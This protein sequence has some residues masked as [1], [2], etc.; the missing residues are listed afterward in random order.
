MTITTITNVRI[1]DGDTV[2]P[3]RTVTLD[4]PTILSVGQPAPAGATIIDGNGGTLLPG[5]IDAHTHTSVESLR[6]ALRFGITTELE[7][8]GHW[9]A[10][11]RATIKATDDLADLR[12]AGFGISAPDGHPSE[13][14]GGPPPEDTTPH[15]S[16]ATGRDADEHGPH[17]FVMPSA[18]TPDEAIAFVKQLVATGSDY[19]KVMIEEG[20]VLASPGL[21][22]MT[23]DTLVAAV[24]AAHEHGKTV[25]AH[26]LTLHAT[27]Q[28]IDAGV[29]GLAHLFIDRPH[30]PQIID[31]IAAAGA[32]VTPCLSLNSSIMGVTGER[33]TTD[34]RVASKLSP[35][36][37]KTLRSSFNTYPK[38]HFDDVLDTVAALHAAGVDILA[39]TDVS[40][41]VPAL[42]GL[43][44]GFS[45]HHELQL[46]VQAGLTPT[47]ALHAAT[48][49]T[50]RRFAL[51]DRGR[52]QAGARADLILVN[53]D[54]TTDITNTLNLRHIW[55]RGTHTTA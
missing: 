8:M 23:N 29:D 25:L 21:P 38:G 24:R 39:G 15:E 26:A 52:I 10:E 43:A 18:T 41:P 3:A 30:T 31:A 22:M 27:Q 32:F 45:V 47:Q 51:T 12:S 33:F 17:G 34:P 11:D 35:K 44:H 50:A 40:M 9:S 5:L 28:A 19:I 1:F 49:A 46:L 48:S 37:L 42:G 6:D 14:M 20:T 16:D 53:G 55:R 2:L 13:L 36:W 54:P 7:M 4:G